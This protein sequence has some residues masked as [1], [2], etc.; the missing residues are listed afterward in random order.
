M[1]NSQKVVEPEN[2][3]LTSYS[4]ADNPETSA[5]S[6]PAELR[7]EPK[8]FIHDGTYNYFNVQ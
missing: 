7:S 3:E 2:V 5:V 4:V 8:D 1:S 6:Q